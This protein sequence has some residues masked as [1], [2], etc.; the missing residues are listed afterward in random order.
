MMAPLTGGS[1][2]EGTCWLQE[3]MK[4]PIKHY[5]PPPPP[6]HSKFD[7]QCKSTVVA[8]LCLVLSPGGPR[9]TWMKS[10]DNLQDKE[11]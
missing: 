9:S 6:Y 4:W 7:K 1:R 8:R 11:G 3:W 2:E 5:S 10:G